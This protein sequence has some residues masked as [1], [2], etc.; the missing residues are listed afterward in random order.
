MPVKTL[1]SSPAALDFDGDGISDVVT[2][3][4]GTSK[5]TFN[6]LKSSD[7]SSFSIILNSGVPVPADY[8]GDGKCDAAVARKEKK[9]IN[10]IIQLS[11]TGETVSRKLGDSSS[12]I[13][14]GCHF[15]SSAK[16]SLATFEGRK[17]KAL[18][19]G[20]S[21]RRSISFD[22]R[23]RT[24]PIGCGDATGDGIDELILL[25]RNISTANNTVSTVSCINDNVDYGVQSS[26]TNFFVL[27]SSAG[28]IPVIGR[29]RFNLS[30][31]TLIRLNSLYDNDR[32]PHFY[33]PA[34]ASF[35]F[36]KFASTDSISSLGILW[37][38]PNSKLI[39]R[40]LFSNP[41]V[42]ET[43]ATL[44]AGGELIKSQR[45]I[46]NPEIPVF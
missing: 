42:G 11:S 40:Q 5:T 21:A 36:G 32:Y 8:D 1:A 44:E 9:G 29:Q 30:G 41:K 14:Y 26:G 12:S 13:I 39:T 37:Q 16:H 20:S 46:A 2:S 22:E 38:K 33:I 35:T 31:Q 3:I 25:T 19:L 7:G 27:D 10:W 4:E 43:V 24:S 28:Q 17:L 18:E 6:I 45:T 23:S 15:L 34:S